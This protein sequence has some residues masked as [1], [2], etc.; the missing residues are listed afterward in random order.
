MTLSYR[1]GS[2]NLMENPADKGVVPDGYVM[3]MNLR[4]L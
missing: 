1:N 4:N 2:E 3:A